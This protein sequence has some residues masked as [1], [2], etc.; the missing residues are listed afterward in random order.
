MDHQ[1]SIATTFSIAAAW[2]YAVELPVSLCSRGKAFVLTNPPRLPAMF[3]VAD[4]VPEL[5]PPKSVERTLRRD[6]I[7]RTPI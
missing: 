4:T 6:G 2:K 1:H 7:G 3:I 5:V